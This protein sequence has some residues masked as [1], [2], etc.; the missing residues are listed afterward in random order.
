MRRWSSSGSA[1]TALSQVI[2]PQGASV[3]SLRR[4]LR[5]QDL[6]QV[7]RQVDETVHD[8]RQLIA[9]LVVEAHDRGVTWDEIGEAFGVSRQSVHERFGPNSRALR[10]SNQ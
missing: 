5:P 6:I 7:A 1:C 3:T 4:P 9:W 2:R 8:L 10:R